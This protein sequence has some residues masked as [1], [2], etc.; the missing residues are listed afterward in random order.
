MGSKIK[1]RVDALMGHP[2]HWTN[3][4]IRRTVRS[5]LSRLK[6]SEEARE[7]VLAHVRPGIKGTYDH[8]DYLAEKREA[9]E[10]WGERVQA[11]TNREAKSI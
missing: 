1:A 6:I 2:P 5:G 4:D 3:H 7:A 8:H 9:L 11:L 10:L